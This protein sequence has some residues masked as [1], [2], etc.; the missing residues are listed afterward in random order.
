M[1]K[2]LTELL[3]GRSIQGTGG[4]GIMAITE[5]LI[6]DLVPLRQRGMYYGMMNA[7][8]TLGSVTGPVVGGAFAQNVTWVSIILQ[9]I[10]MQCSNFP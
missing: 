5:L 6:T 9:D 8:W 1:A 7:V 10:R 2:N 3:V 4:G